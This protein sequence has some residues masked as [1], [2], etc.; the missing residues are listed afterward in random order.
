[1]CAAELWDSPVM[2]AKPQP[3]NHAGHSCHCHSSDSKETG[4]RNVVRDPVC[5]M[6]V[7]RAAARHMAKQEGRR[8]Y[9][10]SSRCQEKFEAEPTEINHNYLILPMFPASTGWQCGTVQRLWLKIGRAHV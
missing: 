9:F 2:T 4:A 8:F 7:A 6:K 3:H 5:G 1:M 10:C